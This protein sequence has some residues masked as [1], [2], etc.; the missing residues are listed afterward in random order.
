MLGRL[1][2]VRLK[3]RGAGQVRRSVPWYGGKLMFDPALP[4]CAVLLV[5]VASLIFSLRG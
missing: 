1:R 4:A 3:F 5:S 2:A